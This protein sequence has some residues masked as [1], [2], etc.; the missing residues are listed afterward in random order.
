MLT[1]TIGLIKT[2]SKVP[3]GNASFFVVIYERSKSQIQFL[4]VENGSFIEPFHFSNLK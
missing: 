3:F 2:C 1:L 4:E